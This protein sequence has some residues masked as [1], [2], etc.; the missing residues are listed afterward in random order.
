MGADERYVSKK[1]FFEP[2]SF[3]RDHEMPSASIN[4]MSEVDSA[5]FITE[6][7]RNKRIEANASVR[8]LHTFIFL[9][10]YLVEIVWA[11]DNT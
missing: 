5:S 10:I 11:M 6:E 3:L 4:S 7:P 8:E 2:L 9:S 1:W